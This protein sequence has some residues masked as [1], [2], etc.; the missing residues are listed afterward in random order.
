MKVQRCTDWKLCCLN[1]PEPTLFKP[2]CFNL[3]SFEDARSA[4][5]LCI[6]NMC[7]HYG[8]AVER[9]YA[10]VREAVCWGVCLFCRSANERPGVSG[11]QVPVL[12][13][14]RW[15]TGLMNSD[16]R[17]LLINQE[18]VCQH[19]DWNSSPTPTCTHTVAHKHTQ[20][21]K[22]MRTRPCRCA[23][24]QRIYTRTH[25]VHI[26]FIWVPCA[27]CGAE[28]NPVFPPDSISRMCL[29]PM[30]SHHSRWGKLLH[31]IWKHLPDVNSEWGPE[32]KRYREIK[33]K[34]ENAYS[35]KT[36]HFCQWIFMF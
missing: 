7:E 22:H 14:R 26:S 15:V 1:K 33:A 12:W 17:Q 34:A 16:V 31:W 3:N 23:H 27:F 6:T 2:Q 28:A 29:L 13:E 10:H 36:N 21:W 9:M 8:H 5:A 32:S 20:A 35:F 4:D 18:T 24:N 11:F 30:S 19:A 25:S